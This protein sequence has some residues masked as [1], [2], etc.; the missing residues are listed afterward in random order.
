MSNKRDEELEH[1]L[2]DAAPDHFAEG[3]RERVVARAARHPGVVGRIHPRG[4]ELT[5]SEILERQF[6]RIVPILAAASILLGVYSWWGG[7]GT[8]DSILDA[9][10]RLP[11]VSIAA[12]YT[13]EVL[14]GDDG[15]D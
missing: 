9:A 15:S 7:R 3:F 1:L 6:M 5:F 4:V 8:S 12:V 2:R 10:L 14:F 11:Q 13:P